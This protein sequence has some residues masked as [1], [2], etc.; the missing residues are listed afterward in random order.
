M[1]VIAFVAISALGVAQAKLPAPPPPTDEAKAAAALTAAKA[2]WGAKVAGYKLCLSQ[3]RAVENYLRNAKAAGK[4]VKP[5]TAVPACVDPG[6]FVAVPSA[7]AAAEPA[8][9]S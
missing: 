6:P 4:D 1:A 8:K 5:A 7:S 3:D 9:T 2:A